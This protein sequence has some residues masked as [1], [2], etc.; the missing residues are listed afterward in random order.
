MVLCIARYYDIIYICKV[1]LI[2]DIKIVLFIKN[3]R[4]YR[5]KGIKTPYK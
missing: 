3:K 4:R 2:F 1:L 5:N